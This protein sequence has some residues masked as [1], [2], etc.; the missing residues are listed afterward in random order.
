MH[1]G[2]E[3]VD[4]DMI[5]AVYANC[6]WE[7]TPLADPD[8]LARMEAEL[9][10]ELPLTTRLYYQHFNGGAFRDT[11]YIRPV[12]SGCPEDI[13]HVLFG[14]RTRND[15]S[16]LEETFVGYDSATEFFDNNDPVTILLFGY[17]I[18]GN[19]LYLDIGE[20]SDGAVGIKLADKQEYYLLAKSIEGF[21]QLLFNA[22]LRDR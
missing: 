7:R 8:E 22:N 13:L 21:F 20:G 17:T 3:A 10:A 1:L 5:E 4:I 12:P 14:V 16:T 2:D 9:G 19:L 6:S 11:V 18:M 15:K